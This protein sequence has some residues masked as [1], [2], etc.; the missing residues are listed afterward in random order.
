MLPMDS[1]YMTPGEAGV[2]RA[3]QEDARLVALDVDA[4]DG[5]RDLAVPQGL[6]RLAGAAAQ[7]VPREQVGGERE[8]QPEVPEPLGLPERDTED[9]QLGVLVAEGE[10]EQR[11]L[12]CRPPLKPPVTD[13]QLLSTCWPMKTRPSEATPR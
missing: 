12:R 13:V 2:H 7:Q 11:E 6:Q 1:A 9:E 8:D 5:R 4:H 3:D 10:A